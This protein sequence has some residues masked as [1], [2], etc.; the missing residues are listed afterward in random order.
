MFD[1]LYVLTV[2]Q[3]NIKFTQP[4][5]AVVAALL[6]K[7]HLIIHVGAGPI[8]LVYGTPSQL[9][10]ELIN[11][12]ILVSLFSRALMRACVPMCGSV[13]QC[14]ALCCSVL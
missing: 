8:Q 1:L 13:W 7:H 2:L 4:P 11:D 10:A 12:S 9:A 6:H 5:D 14:D 3:K